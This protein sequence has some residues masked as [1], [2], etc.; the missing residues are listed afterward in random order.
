M[1]KFSD[2]RAKILEKWPL[3]VIRPTIETLLGL[4]SY[5]GNPL[6]KILHFTFTTP[7]VTL[8]TCAVPKK[9]RGIENEPTI[10]INDNRLF[11]RLLYT[12]RR[13]QTYLRHLSAVT[14]P[15]CYRIRGATDVTA[16]THK[17]LRP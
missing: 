8:K 12:V 4:P 2:V 1:D 14:S 11:R 10:Q 15:T 9:G 13:S 17:T 7:P 3:T 5:L 16:S 6:R